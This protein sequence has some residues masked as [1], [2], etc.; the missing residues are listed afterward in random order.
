MAAAL[1]S[2]WRQM[3]L[4]MAMFV[5]VNFALHL[6]SIGYVSNEWFLFEIIFGALTVVWPFVAKCVIGVLQKDVPTALSDILQLASGDD[7]LK[8]YKKHPLLRTSILLAAGFGFSVIG[9]ASAVLFGSPWSGLQRTLFYV[10]TLLFFFGYGMLGCLYTASML[11]VQRIGQLTVIPS[12]SW[13]T[14]AIKGIYWSYFRIFAMGCLLYVA[15]LV[16]VWVS[17]G[18]AW[19]AR[20]TYIGQLWV[21]PPGVMVIAFFVWF[22]Y[23]THSLLMAYKSQAENMIAL[24]IRRAFSEWRSLKPSEEAEKRIAT[25]LQWQKEVRSETTWVIDFR[26]MLATIATLLLPTVKAVWDL[27]Q[28]RS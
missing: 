6:Q 7:E 11:L 5:F 16:A 18:G 13:P 17:P 24:D 20:N 26:A 8:T 2:H 9:L 10:W 25:L 22:N 23:Y 19:I 3:S 1:M 27:T 28:S 21:F 12:L 4:C 15:G 14:W